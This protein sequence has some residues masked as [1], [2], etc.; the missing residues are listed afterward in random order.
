M[1]T[2]VIRW[3][4]TKASL[5]EAL[6]QICKCGGDNHISGQRTIG[7]RGDDIGVNMSVLRND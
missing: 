2:I 5:L 6:F 4:N 7:V 1:I 3:K